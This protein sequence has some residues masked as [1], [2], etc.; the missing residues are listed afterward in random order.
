[1]SH[2]RAVFPPDVIA[3]YLANGKD[4]T[5]A[6]YRTHWQ[7]LRRWLVERGVSIRPQGR[8]LGSSATGAP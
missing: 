3:H 6:A 8:R 4:R 1:M 7:T 5:C 2:P